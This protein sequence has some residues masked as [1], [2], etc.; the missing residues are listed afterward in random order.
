M[1]VYLSYEELAERCCN[2]VVSG[3]VTRYRDTELEFRPVDSSSDR[4]IFNLWSLE[5]EYRSSDLNIPR[6]FPPTSFL[7]HH[8]YFAIRSY[9]I[10][11]VNEM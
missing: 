5:G 1:E 9:I 7:I 10:Y 8:S 4:V 3:T 6:P 11:A 2:G